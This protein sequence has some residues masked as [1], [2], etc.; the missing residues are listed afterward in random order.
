[1]KK[2]FALLVLF[3]GINLSAGDI[4]IAEKGQAKADIVLPSA[5]SVYVKFAA[6]ELKQYL[7]KI[8]GGNFKITDKPTAAVKIHLG[9]SPESETAGLKPETLKKDGFFIKAKG[10]DIF[11]VGVDN[12]TAKK[13]D[14]FNLFYDEPRRATLLG[15]YE[16]LEQ[17]GVRWPAP[18]TVNEY[19]PRLTDLKISE[20][21]QEIEPFFADRQLPG[22]WDF[23][24]K[25]PDSKEYCTTANDIFLWGLRLKLSGRGMVVGCHSERS[26][27]RPDVAGGIKDLWADHPERFALI[28]GERNFE[29][30]CWTDPAITEMW[31]TAAN[32]YFSGKTPAEAGFPY[33]KPYLNSAWP[34]PFI[35]EDDFMIDPMDHGA[36]CDGRCRCQRCNE[37][38]E[39]YPCKDDSEIIWKVIAEVA[40]DIKRKHPGKFISTLV[41]PPKMQL[42]KYVK[43]PDNIRV[44][45]CIQ[46]PLNVPT[47]KRMNAELD[48][49]KIWS[50]ALNAN[51]PP[52]WTYQCEAAFGRK[53]PGTPETY[54][55]LI[56]G[57]LKAFRNDIA[58]MF[59]EQHALSHTYRNL[60]AY[61]TARLLWN[62]DQNVDDILNDY[63]KSYYGPA[64]EPVQKLFKR[65]E[66]NWIKYWK[67]ATPDKPKTEDIGLGAP[68]KELQKLVWSK[69]YTQEE[70]QNIDNILKEAAKASAGNTV[71][72]KRIEMLRTWIFDIMKTERAEVMDKEETRKKIIAHVSLV[73]DTPLPTEWDKASVYKLASA[74]RTKTDLLATGEFQLLHDSKNLYLKAVLK[75]PE[76]S[77][78]KT[79]KE[80]NAGDHDIWKDNDLEIF[81]YSEESKDLWQI[82]I[83]DNGKWSSQKFNTGKASWTQMENLQVKVSSSADGWMVEAAIPL[84]QLG[85]GELR[86]NL[87]RSRQIKDQ[88]NELSTWSPL[89][90][91][92]NWHAS[93]NYGTL[94][95]NNQ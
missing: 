71:C 93:E 74:S 30:S 32:A 29:Y 56:D 27:K 68:A 54:P 38:R 13:V 12:K 11:I 72:G 73:K 64:A 75:E 50:N 16:F 3:I 60:D 6:D 86:F 80:R 76:L 84:K 37:F 2:L 89:A 63:F 47:P 67:M 9:Q 79:V 34:G 62:P 8:T 61:V 28:K 39:K 78:S 77:K 35:C 95:F 46:G 52:L 33:L 40:E 90:K 41:Y 49:V 87:A 22:F 19:V 25:F 24:S 14:L 20:G 65:F 5:P 1:M 66:D 15:V 26:L 10:N 94:I 23:M 57:F 85:P 21:I 42:P 91:V 92:G 69:V 59:F 55:H 58:G 51:K 17:I 81:I 70:M 88:P 48:L 83:N 18:G 82:M 44:R 36:S 43:I 4:V 45:I 31:K 53:L 7:D